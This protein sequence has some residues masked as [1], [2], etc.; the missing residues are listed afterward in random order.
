MTD[1]E[2]LDAVDQERGKFTRS[3]EDLL[4]RWVDELVARR[5]YPSHWPEPTPYQ[6]MS[7]WG[8][9]WH[10]YSEPLNCPLCNADL[11]DRVTGPPFKRTIGRSD[12]R[13]DRI[14]SWHCPDCKGSWP[15]L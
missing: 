1:A 12:R 6:R 5:V 2:L 7:G 9:Y 3:N 10:L 8:A 15:R 11:C 4:R 13:L 14:V